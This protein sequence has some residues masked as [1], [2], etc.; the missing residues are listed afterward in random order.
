VADVILADVAGDVPTVE[1]VTEPVSKFV[2]EM[3]L[4]PTT[5][6]A[7]VGLLYLLL[8]TFVDGFRD[9]GDDHPGRAAA[10][11]GAEHRPGVVR[12]DRGDADGGGVDL[13]ARSWTSTSA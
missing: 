2:T 5:T 6:I 7:V 1:A 8:G 11:R 9:D 3:P 13:A 10:A 12:R 4:T